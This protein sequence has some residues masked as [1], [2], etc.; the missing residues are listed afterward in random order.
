VLLPKS[1]RSLLLYSSCK[2]VEHYTRQEVS[3]SHEPAPS[4]YTALHFER[5]VTQ[6]SDIFLP[7]D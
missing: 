7:R 3:A 1:I 5:V 6:L 4:T 2:R